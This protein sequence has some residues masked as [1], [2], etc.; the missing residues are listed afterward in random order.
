MD[1]IDAET[2]ERAEAEL[3]K[4]VGRRAREG[5]AYLMALCAGTK[6]NGERCT[7]TVEP[8]Q[9]HCW[10]HDPANADKRRRAAS[11]GGKG[12]PSREIRD[13]K[14]ELED[15]AEGVLTGKVDRG[16]GAVVN[17]ILNTRLR[18]VEL[19]RKIRETDE[20]QAK[21]EEMAEALERQKEGSAY[22]STG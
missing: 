2:V 8:P 20:L 5:G 21:L 16:K 11:R 3:D 22:G 13:L 1:L 19:E 6:G 17:Q 7:A 15:L 12:K 9:T 18:A 14:R 10:W 4:F